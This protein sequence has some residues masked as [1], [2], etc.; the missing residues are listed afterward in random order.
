MVKIPSLANPSAQPQVSTRTNCNS[1]DLTGTEHFS[2]T[3]YPVN[4]LSMLHLTES[5][6]PRSKKS[7]AP[8]APIKT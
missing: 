2:K 6:Q 8:A 3:R 5:K 4:G 7:G 1:T